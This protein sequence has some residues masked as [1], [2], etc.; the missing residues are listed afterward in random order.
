MMGG[1]GVALRVRIEDA[2]GDACDR[3]AQF[4]NREMLALEK[5]IDLIDKFQSR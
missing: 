2:F 1:T 5:V 3:G 4:T